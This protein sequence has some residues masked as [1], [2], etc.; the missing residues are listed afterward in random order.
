MGFK[1]MKSL[2]LSSLAASLLI[3]TFAG[4]GSPQI[5]TLEEEWDDPPCVGL[6]DCN[7]AFVGDVCIN[8]CPNAAVHSNFIRDYIA[9][10]DDLREA[11]FFPESTASDSSTS[12]VGFADC[13][14]QRC[15]FSET[16]PVD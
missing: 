11:C 15:V 16:D 13:V 4:C 6:D 3:L 14:D 12:C 5:M 1:Q 10:Y 2:I 8:S 9:R 7:P